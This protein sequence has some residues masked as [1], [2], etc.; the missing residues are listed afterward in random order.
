MIYGFWLPLCL[1]IVLSVLLWFTDSDYPFVWPLCCLFF[2]DLQILITSLFGHCVVCSSLIYRFWLPLCLAIVLSVLLWFTDSDYPFVWPLCCLFFF[3]L[4]I[5]ITPLFGHC[6]I[7]SSL[8]YRFWLPLCLA[9]VLSVLL[10]FMD[11]DYPFV[12]PLCCLFFFDLQILITPLFGHCVVCSSLIYGF[13]LPLC[14]AIVLSVLLWFTDS[15]YPFVW[16]LCCLFFFDLQILI[17]PLFGHCV[18]CSSL[19]YR[20]WLP[21]CLAIVLSVLLWFMDSDYPFVWPLCCLFFFDLQILITPLFG[22][23]VVCSSL[24]YGFWLPLCLAIVL[25]VLLW[26]TDSDYPFVWPL[27]CLFFFDLQILITPLFGHCVVCSSLIYRF[28]LPLCLA[29]VLSV[30]LWSTDSDYPFVWP[31][32]CLFF[33]DLQILITPLFGHYVVCSSLIYRFWLPLC[34]AIVLSVLLWFTVSDY[35]FVWPLCCLF[36]F[37]LQILITSL[38]GHCVVCSSLIYR[39]WLPLCL[40]FVL[41]VLLW[42]TDSDYPFVWPLCCLFFFDLQILITPL[43]GHCVVCSSLIYRFWLPLCLA[44]VLSVL[45]WFTDSDYP[46]VWP[47]CCLFFFDLQIL[48]TSL[49]GHCV[50]C[51]SLI[52]RFWLPLCLAIVL[53]SSLIY[54]FWLLL[55]LAIVLS[56]L[57]WFT[58]SDYPFVWPLC[59]L[60]F[61]DLQILITPLFGH[62]VVCSSLIYRFW[63]PLCLAIVLCSS[64]IYGFWLLLC[65]A[66]VLSVLLWSTD[67][68]YPFVWPLCC[69]FIFELQILITPLFG[70]CVVCSSLIYRFWLPL[71]LAIVLSVHLWFTDSDYPFVWPLCCLFFFD[72]QI[73]IIPLFGHCVVCSFLIYGFWLPLCLAIVLSV[74]LWFTDSDYPFVWPLCCLFFFDLQILITPLFGHCVV[75]SPLIYRFWLPLCLAIVLSVLLWSTDSDYPFVWPLCCLFLFDLQIL[76]TPLF[77]HC[78]VCSSLIYRFWLPLCLAIVLSVLLWF[79]DSDYP[80]VWPLCCLF[81]FD[82]RILITPLF[83]HCVVCSSLIYRFWLPLCLAIVLSVLLWFTDS[84]YPFVWPLC[85]LFFFDLRIL[86]TP[87]FGHCVVCSSLIYRFWLPLCL[88][89]MLSVLLWFTDSDYPFVWPLCCLFFFDLQILITPLFGHCVVCS[90]LIYRFWLPLCLAFVLSVLLWFTD[91]DY[92]FVWPLCCLFFFD[93]QILITSLF[94]HCV[95]CSSLIYR[96]WLPLCLAIVLSVLLWFT[97]SD[98]PFVWPLCCLFFF[99][100]R[101]L[102]TPLFGHCVVCSSLIY[103]FWLPLCLAIVLS[104]LLWFTDSDYPFVWPLCCLFFFDL[105]ILITSLFGHCVVFFFDLRILTTPLFGHCVV[106]S[107]VIYR[108]WLPL[109]LAIVLSVLLWITDSDYP[110]VWPLCCLFFF[111]LQILITPL[112][113]HCGVCSSL[114]YR[115][116]LPLC[117]AIVLSVVLWSTDSDYPFVWPLC[118]LFFFDLQILITPLFGHCVVCS[119]LIYRLWLPL[120]L[121]IVLSVLFWFTDSDYPFVW[122][123]CCLFF[124]DWRILITPLFGHCVV[125]SSLIYRF[126]LPLCLAIV[127]SVL[128]WFTDSD[129]SFVWPLCCQFLFELQILITSLFGHCVVCSSL[130]YRFWL[131]LCL[132]IVLCSSLIYGFWLLLCLAIVLSVLLWSTDSDYPFVWPLCCLFFFDLQILITSLFGHC[133][134]CSSLIYRFWLLLCLAIVL[135]VLL[136]FTDSDYPFVWPLCCVLLWFTILTTPL[137]GHCVVCSSLIY[138]FWLPLCLAIVLSVLLWFIDSD[139]PFVWSLCCLFFF[140]LQILITPLFGHCVVCSSLIYRFWLPLCL[141]IVLSVLLWFTDFDY[142][143]VWPLCCLFFFDLQIL[144]TPLFGHCVVC[145]SLIYGFWL[146]LCL[147]IV[148]SVLLWFTDSDYPFVWPLCCLFFCDLQILITPLFGHCVVCSSLNYRFWLPLCLAIVLSVLLW[149]TDSD[150][151]FVWPLCCLFIFDLQILITPLFGHC[152]VCSSLI[153][154]FWLP[155]C[156]AIV[157]SVL[158][159]F[160]DSD[161]PFVWPLCCLFFFDLQI[162]ITPLFGHCVACSSLIYRFWLLLCLAIVLSVSLW[163]TDS[164]YL[165]VW[166]LCCLFFF[167]LQILITSLLGHCVVFFFDLRILTTPLFGHCV[168]CSSLI[169][170]FWLP[171]CLAIVLSVLLWFTDSDFLFVWPLCCLFF[172]DLQILITPLFGHCVVCSSLIYRLWLPLCLAIVLSVLLWFTDSDYPFVWPLCC[173]FFFDLHILITPLFGHCVVCSSLIY[174]FW[175]PLCLAIVLSVLL[176]ITDSDYPFVWPLCCVLLWSTD[177]DYSFVR[178]LCCLFFFD[179]QILITPLFGHCVVCSSL[180]YRF[181]LPLCLAI[182]LYSSLIYGFWLLLCLAI[183]LSVLLWFT[184]SDYPFVWP[185]CCLFFFDLRIMITPLFGHCVVCSSLIYRFW[186]L[187]CLAIVL[188]VLL[189]FTDSDYPFVWPLCCV[190]LWSTD[191]DYSFVW[192]LCCLFFFDLQILI[193]PLFGHC[194]VCSSLIYRFWLLLCLAIVLSVLLWFTDSDYP[195]VWPLCCLFFFD[196]QILITPLFGH[197]VVC[198]S[199]I[200][201]FWL[202]LCLAIVLSV[203]LWSTDSDY[204][205]VWPLCCLFFFD[206]QIL[207]TPLFDHCVVCSS[208]IY[209]FWLPL[210]LAIVLSVLLWFTD[211]DY[212]FQVS[213]N[214]SWYG[215]NM[216]EE[217]WSSFCVDN[218]N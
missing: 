183:V 9:I 72:L 80:F 153:Y 201:R 32:C 121:A 186:L 142:P 29:I 174:R 82:L 192:P 98:Y 177:S 68:D 125:C 14:L 23:Y 40:A 175:L 96:F 69:L 104:V 161:Y 64:L 181:W 75:C 28:W 105:Q 54:G 118:C 101:I 81:F 154:R 158:L 173:L 149:F 97:D 8:I 151:P 70:H 207:I 159:W 123:L 210:C 106:C 20:F 171:L 150:Y 113:G 37:D 204:P 49:F 108:F 12:W 74:L 17:T 157:L 215:F 164:D 135:S 55:C 182:V 168:V 127:L 170:R 130:I 89:I 188:S 66:I 133:V 42:F 100:L 145:S 13:W 93:L 119:S 33:F 76:I 144:I 99:D 156:L 86:I 57:L 110:F 212:P 122:P 189:W 25:S 1:A 22:H 202:P 53:C 71:C 21:L 90:S 11:S 62:C 103:R 199:L 88:A 190:L 117:L 124:F 163:I 137:F 47:L 44:I 92:P 165:F 120:C 61:F 2:F 102:T 34:L 196:L 111:D 56:V 180:I 77:G 7:C 143:F 217:S 91:S 203:L 59:C 112:F 73:L 167:D 162:L 36:F 195:F 178:P 148:L 78:V 46:F 115:F 166:P 128:L 3:D 109:C 116:W 38:F 136:W 194:V 193:T 26:F 206:L 27:C 147:A 48:I 214:S 185:L 41:S 31:L 83:G 152:V 63:L 126:W 95:V 160:T 172:F 94:G 4:Q 208:L 107:S 155:L 87:L 35:P 141:A 43:F 84:D 6:V 129:Y 187:L 198:S 15:D 85:C 191:S 65:L 50:V 216:S 45:L 18:I 24:I 146:P 200:Y 209:R 10:W 213:S 51:S 140:D 79:T 211:S 114:I 131:P 184:D 39:F 58:D 197:C 5:L 16:P 30:L 176:W 139:Y 132:T 134:V 218:C 67:S 169:Y 138:R 179:L 60:F 205:F 19:I 52:Y